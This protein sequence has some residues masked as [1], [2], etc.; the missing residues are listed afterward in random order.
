MGDRYARYLLDKNERIGAYLTGSLVLLSILAFVSIFLVA[1]QY[2]DYSQVIG[3]FLLLLSIPA[4]TML[5]P[6]TEESRKKL[7]LFSTGI[8]AIGLMGLF[9][10]FTSEKP[11][12]FGT[13]FVLGIFIYQWVF[14]AEMIKQSNSED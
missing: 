5:M 12:I 10:M 13:L 8:L 3:I 2:K 1:A 7:I 6:E 4:G 14:N 9:S 11:G